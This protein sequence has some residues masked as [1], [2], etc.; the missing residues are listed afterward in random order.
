MD[1]EIKTNVTKTLAQLDDF[2]YKQVPFA[3]ALALTRIAQRVQKSSQSALSKYF[4]IRTPWV[5]KGIRIEPARKNDWPYQEAVVG[6][7]DP[8]M[9]LQ[10]LGGV[11]KGLKQNVAIP[12]GARPTKLSTT[13][14]SM[15]P[16]KL[17]SSKKQHAF[18]SK[19]RSAPAIVQANPSD[20]RKL[21]VMYLLKPT[22]RMK[23][24]WPFE[25]NATAIVQSQY[26]R[27]FGAA[28]AR[29]IATAK[30]K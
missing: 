8:F 11:K 29:A 24:R 10:A 19:R 23:A 18:I 12:I 4:T 25:S 17:L 9:A 27:E 26:D 3:S 2:A 6:S 7:K 28:L 22:V 30:S 5:S 21:Q 15:W 20:P 13:P 16:K 14:R 1:I